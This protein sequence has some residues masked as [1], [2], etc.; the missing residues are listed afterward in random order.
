LPQAD[1]SGAMTKK[2]HSTPRAS[3]EPLIA[4]VRASMRED[5]RILGGDL[6]PP[7]KSVIRELEAIE[8]S[9]LSE[10]A[11]AVGRMYLLGQRR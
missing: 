11:K 2:P 3:D 1:A 4:D 5:E 8:A 10:A 6:I 7:D 9:G